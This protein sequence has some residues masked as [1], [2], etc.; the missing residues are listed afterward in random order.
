MSPTTSVKCA[1]VVLTP[2]KHAKQANVIFSTLA[3]FTTLISPLP[4]IAIVFLLIVIAKL[5]PH[6]V[7][8]APALQGEV[9]F[10]SPRQADT[11]NH[12]YQIKT[13]LFPLMSFALLLVLQDNQR[14]LIWRDSLPDVSYRQLVVLLKREH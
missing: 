5:H 12:T 4:L 2:S 14:R 7:W 13:V 3:C 6:Q 8:L 9:T 1:R 10:V 11:V